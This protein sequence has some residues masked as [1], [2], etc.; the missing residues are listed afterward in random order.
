MAHDR[1]VVKNLLQIEEAITH[2]SA[3]SHAGDVFGASRP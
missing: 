2:K 1:D 3:K